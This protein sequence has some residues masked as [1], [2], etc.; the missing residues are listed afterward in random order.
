M[1]AVGAA[2]FRPEYPIYV[3]SGFFGGL[4]MLR[5]T[6]GA[7]LISGPEDLQLIRERLRRSGFQH[8]G[9]PERWLPPLPAYLRWRD[10][11]VQ[12]EEVSAGSGLLCRV[13][14][15]YSYLIRLHRGLD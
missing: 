11:F 7:Q 3:V 14:G 9:N 10:A 6:D 5:F 1:V 15:P 13:T 12:I 8:A 4:C 2:A